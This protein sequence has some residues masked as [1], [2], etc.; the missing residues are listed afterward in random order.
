M[1]PR[2]PRVWRPLLAIVGA[3][4][5]ATAGAGASVAST[6]LSPSTT[7]PTTVSATTRATPLV[8]GELADYVNP[9][10]GTS[11]YPLLVL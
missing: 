5:L 1:T 7:T 4:S 2:P 6:P 9:L 3:I 10:I 8:A 11:G